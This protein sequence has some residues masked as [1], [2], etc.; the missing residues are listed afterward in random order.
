[1]NS[2]WTNHKRKIASLIFF[3]MSVALITTSSG[4]SVGVATPLF[5]RA[6]LFPSTPVLHGTSSL[7]LGFTDTVKSWLKSDLEQE[8]EQLRKDVAR[9]REEKTRLI[10]VLQENE[11]LRRIVDLK[12][13]RPEFKLVPARV[14]SRDTSPYFRVLHIR[15]AVDPETPIQPRMPVLVAEG[16]VGQIHRVFDKYAEVIIVSDPRHRVDAVAQRTRAQAI[17]EGLGHEHDYFA[18]LAY[19]RDIDE[20]RVGDLIVTSGMGEH[21]PRELVIGSVSSVQLAERGLFQEAQISPA[22]DFSRLEE[23]FVLVGVE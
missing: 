10:G 6:A 3:L 1:V 8:N 12:T 18:K 20:V 2:L 14:I 23:V 19:L 21:M 5:T 13:K 4:L 9:L 7:V 15:I 17:V 22:V 11:R 16:L